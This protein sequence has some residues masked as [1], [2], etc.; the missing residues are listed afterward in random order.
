MPSRPATTTSTI[1]SATSSTSPQATNTAITPFRVR[2]RARPTPTSSR[3]FPYYTDYSVDGPDVLPFS[4]SHGIYA[5]DSWK[6][7]PN[8]TIDYGLRYEI[9]APFNDATHQL[10]NFDPN[11][12]GG[13]VVVQGQTGLNLVIPVFAESIGTTPIVTNQTAGLPTTLRKT[14]LRRHR[15]PI[16]V[17][18]SAL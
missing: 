17:Y 5:Q 6:I 15:S 1:T 10:A 18:V 12:P 7:L 14:L 11:Y 4:H 2:S 9:H 3:D 13:R 8:L 16:R